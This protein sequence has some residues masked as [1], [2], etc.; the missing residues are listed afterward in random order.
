MNEN[1]EV[2][3]KQIGDYNFDMN[4]IIGEGYSSK[5]YK[6]IHMST[7]QVVAIKVISLETYNSPIQKSLLSN[8]IKILLQIDNPNLLRVYEISQS[9]NNTYIVSEYCEGASLE[10][11]LKQE[12]MK[13]EKVIDVLTQICKGLL[14]LHQ[15]NIIHRDI[16]PANVLIKNG[17]FKLVDFGFALIENQYDSI[18]KRYNVG[19][20]LYMAPEIHLFNQY[21]EKSDVWALGIMLHE[22]LFKTAPKFKFNDQTL[23][24]EIKENCQTLDIIDSKLIVR[25]L[26][27]MLQLEP[28]DR[29]TIQQILQIISEN[30][31]S[32]SSV[33]KQASNLVKL[34][35]KSVS[36][37]VN[38][39]LQSKGVRSPNEIRK[40]Y[41]RQRLSDNKPLS[42]DDQTLAN[43]VRVQAQKRG[44]EFEITQF[45]YEDEVPRQSTGVNLNQQPFRYSHQQSDSEI[46]IELIEQISTDCS[47]QKSSK[48]K[49]LSQ[50]RNQEVDL[51][52]ILKPTY[53]FCEFIEQ[54]IQNFPK[55]DDDLILKMQFLLRKLL[56]IKA[57]V[58][59]TFAPHKIKSQLDNWISQLHQYYQKIQCLVNLNLDKTF[60][61]FFNSNLDDQGKLLTMYIISLAN[62]MVKKSNEIKIV[63][64]ILEDNLQHQNDP[65]L[66][67]RKWVIQ[68]SS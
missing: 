26:E 36:T 52:V 24:Q 54:I 51:P 5:V 3:R 45:T 33:S 65:F 49:L 61:L 63:I 41:I 23:M 39:P 17:I 12:P 43:L 32:Q 55:Q 47:V 22:M 64:E 37:Q 42:F 56:A 48:Q 13:T 35:Q 40:K 67:A 15:K 2:I 18:L 46:N 60:Q 8:E 29:L 28:E 1:K 50:N 19:T 57:K 53:E 20:P 66:F 7:H 25:L 31:S 59:Y 30:Q 27:G 11:L 16:K 34:S 4:D 44:K 10:E 58:F 62:Q 21:S 9:A 14:G 6:G 68:K 38:S